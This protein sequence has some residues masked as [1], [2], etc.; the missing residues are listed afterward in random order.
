MEFI[1]IIIAI[2]LFLIFLSAQ[3]SK[4]STKRERYGEAVGNLASMAADTISNAAHSITEPADK[5]KIRI[6]KQELSSRNGSLYRFNYYSDKEHIKR[7]LTVDDY[8]KS[9]LDTLGISE[10][11]WEKIALMVFYIGTIRKLSRESHDYTKK[12]SIHSREYMI[13]NWTESFLKDYPDTLKKALIFF[14]IKIEEWIEY[15]D[16]VIEMYDLFDNPD[17]EEFG[18]ISSILPIENNM[19]LL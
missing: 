11:R 6:A 4:K 5:K 13:N 3:D 12:N 1:V 10:E 7:L 19:H 18:F 9:V 16:A 17:L 14:N 8:F 2:I 15:G